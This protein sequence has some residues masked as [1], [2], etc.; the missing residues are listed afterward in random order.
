MQQRWRGHSK[1]A[2][3]TLGL[4]RVR[5]TDPQLLS[6]RDA[7]SHDILV[8]LTASPF[9]RWE[10]KVNLLT[11]LFSLKQWKNLSPV[12][13][14]PAATLR[15]QQLTPFTLAA[16]LWL[17]TSALLSMA[18]SIAEAQRPH[19]LPLGWIFFKFRTN[20]IHVTSW[21]KNHIFL[22]CREE[23]R[24][25]KSTLYILYPFTSIKNIRK[26]PFLWKSR[27]D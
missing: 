16:A 5:E 24:K 27:G 1:G 11:H 7:V 26:V 21:I 4:L 12:V 14:S 6:G 10:V 18:I 17:S 13:T 3:C 9:L 15:F 8:W 19:F 2:K 25:E 23:K 20:L 22:I